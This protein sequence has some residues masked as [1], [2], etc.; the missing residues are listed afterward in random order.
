MNVHRPALDD[1]KSLRR[2]AFT[3]KILISGERLDGG[4]GRKLAEIRLRQAGEKLATA[5]RVDDGEVLN[6]ASALVITS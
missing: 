6:S 2:I 4:D 3:K 5:Q 1:V